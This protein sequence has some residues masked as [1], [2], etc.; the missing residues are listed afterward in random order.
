M[1][2]FIPP[3]GDALDYELEALTTPAGDGIQFLLGASLPSVSIQAA[4]DHATTSLT[5]NGTIT[6]DGGEDSTEVGFVYDTVSVTDNP[7]NVAPGATDYGSSVSDTGVFGEAPFSKGLTGLTQATT[8]YIRAYAMNTAGYTY[9]SEVSYVTAGYPTV[10]TEAVSGISGGTAQG[11]GNITDDGE[12]PILRRGFVIATSTKSDPG[13]VAPEASD[14]T[15]LVDETGTFGEGSYDLN[16]TGLASITSYYVRAFIQ[17]SVGY[18]YGDEVS[19][20]TTGVPVLTTEGADNETFTDAD[21]NGDITYDGGSTLTR[22]GFVFSTESHSPPGNTSPEASDYEFIESESGTFSEGEYTLH[23]TALADN[24]DYFLRAFAQNSDGFAYGLEVPF[25]SE[26]FAPTIISVDPVGAN[27]DETKEIT[28]SG[29]NFRAGVTVTIGGVTCTDIEVVDGQT[30]TCVAPAK[31]VQ[32]EYPLLLT[33]VDGKYATT[34]FYYMEL[35]PNP[36]QKDPV[37]AK[38]SVEAVPFSQ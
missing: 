25:S 11:N 29:S 34:A 3:L 14:Y 22:R 35:L 13:H 8:Y 5:A 15:G 12:L 18:V 28:I 26:Y 7:G 16:L 10:D 9:S 17:N 4:T 30:I 32:G 21:L 37:V 20:T 36:I 38:F 23:T 24:T 2:A 6:A 31:S 19:F 27:L 1:S 33:N